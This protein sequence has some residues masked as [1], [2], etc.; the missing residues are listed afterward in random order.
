M[1]ANN[2]KLTTLQNFAKVLNS[3]LGVAVTFEQLYLQL[4]LKC[5]DCLSYFNIIW[6]PWF[7]KY[8]IKIVSALLFVSCFRYYCSMSSS[9]CL[10]FH[11]ND[12]PFCCWKPM[13]LSTWWMVYR[14]IEIIITVLLIFHNLPMARCSITFWTN[15]IVHCVMALMGE[16]RGK[17]RTLNNIHDMIVMTLLRQ[18]IF[19]LALN[20]KAPLKQSHVSLHA[21][22]QFLL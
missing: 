16:P 7:N 10:M 12:I 20:T 11:R 13:Y 4:M 9:V 3:W 1:F 15:M 14:C 22:I 19:I 2:F 8:R 17:F 18:H 6:H 5:F 21:H